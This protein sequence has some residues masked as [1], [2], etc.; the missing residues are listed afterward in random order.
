M[1]EEVK[2]RSWGR[3]RPRANVTVINGE[4]IEET[5]QGIE[6]ECKKRALTSQSEQAKPVSQSVGINLQQPELLNNER[7]IEALRKVK[8]PIP[9]YSDGR[10]SRE[11]LLFLYRTNVLPKPQRKRQIWKRRCK[12]QSNYE[13]SGGGSRD[14]GELE[15]NDG[16]D[17]WATN[18]AG[19]S[20]VLT[21][22]K[23]YT[24]RAI[25]RELVKVCTN[26]ISLLFGNPISESRLLA[27][28]Y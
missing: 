20:A 3:T 9:V 16:R 24:F 14:G 23:R 15:V 6:E 19:L 5:L 10:P 26:I 8:V 25:F 7:L 17:D 13:G 21:E 12:E 27:C 28:M 4:E 11:R 1:S 18:G 2:K 22:K